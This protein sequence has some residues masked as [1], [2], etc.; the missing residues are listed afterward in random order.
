MK[1]SDFVSMAK[2]YLPELQVQ[3]KDESIETQINQN[4]RQHVIYW[5]KNEYQPALLE[6]L[7]KYYPDGFLKKTN[8]KIYAV[9]FTKTG[10]EWKTGNV[11]RAWH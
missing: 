5:R 11:Y 1:D 8:K 9:W 2:F 10:E 4:W 7:L 6:V 3:D